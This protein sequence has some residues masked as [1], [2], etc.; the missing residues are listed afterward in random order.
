LILKRLAAASRRAL[1]N[2]PSQLCH[3][4]NIVAWNWFDRQATRIGKRNK[5]M[6]IR[7]ALLGGGA[8]LLLSA[9]AAVAAPAIVQSDLN[10][11]SGPG[12]QY[13][14]VGTVQSGE[15]VDVA[16]CTG[17]WC[18]ISFRGGTGYANQNYLAMAG[19]GGP[20]YAAVAPGY[21]PG[22]VDEAP[23]YA[24]NDGYY[25]DYSP[26]VG[27]FVS[28]GFRRH[29]HGWDGRPGWDGGHRVG[30]NWQGGNGNWQGRGNRVG[31]VGAPTSQPG[32]VSPQVRSGG[33]GGPQM[34][35]PTGMRSGGVGAPG[36]GAPGGGARM[37]G[38]GGGGGAGGGRGGGVGG[39]R[40]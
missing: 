13:Q 21:D 4:R 3:A 1:C 17:S 26:G 27:V 31:A 11:R 24:Y 5:P 34:S 25:D 39:P 40:Q 32:S 30:G 12:A 9:G 20:G 15:T 2:N 18:Q 35:A 23:D 28:P 10:V 22:Y 36:V 33:V 14:V 6:T 8:A 38:G 16:G 7:H 19:G 37:G 29:R